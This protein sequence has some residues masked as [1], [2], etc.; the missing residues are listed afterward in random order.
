MLA[1]ALT[2]I[3]KV[4][5]ENIYITRTWKGLR[6]PPKLLPLGGNTH[7]LTA[8]L[9]IKGHR[10]GLLVSRSAGRW[11]VLRKVSGSHAVP[12]TM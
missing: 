8:W 2:K 9:F 3:V 11:G 12:G 1:S 7:I 4:S 5:Q 10:R 6:R